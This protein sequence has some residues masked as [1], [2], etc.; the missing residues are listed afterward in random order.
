MKRMLLA[1]VAVIAVALVAVAV[2]AA[3]TP[4]P[5]P[6]D[7]DTYA[8]A[9]TLLR[10]IADTVE[11]NQSLDL[12]SAEDMQAACPWCLGEIFESLVCDALT[13]ANSF[14]DTSSC[15]TEYSNCINAANRNAGSDSEGD[16]YTPLANS[17]VNHAH[18]HCDLEYERCT[19]DLDDHND[20]QSWL[21][22]V[23]LP[24]KSKDDAP[25]PP[26]SE[27]GQPAP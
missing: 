19:R 18:T 20:G 12:P 7:A 22:Q 21:C 26:R 13:G 16:Y 6:E 4:N 14:M 3:T 11:T 10:H 25:P 9:A 1:A 8:K 27:L 15:D 5:T 17:E 23:F 2:S 24:L